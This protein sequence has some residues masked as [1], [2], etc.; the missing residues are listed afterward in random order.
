M[1]MDVVPNKSRS[2]QIICNLKVDA[3]EGPARS[4]TARRVITLKD[5]KRSKT[6]RVE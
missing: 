5:R 4:A 3:L 6:D 1:G 2:L